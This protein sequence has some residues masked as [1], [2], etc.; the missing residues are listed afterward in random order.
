MHERLDL[1]LGL[2]VAPELV[3]LLGE[4]SGPL[5]CIEVE[6]QTLWWP[7]GDP[8]EPWRLDR[9][10]ADRL[11]ASG[12][13]VLA[14]GVSAPVGSSTPPD[15]PAVRAFAATVASVGAVHASEHLSFNAVGSGAARMD[16]GMF[17]PPCPTD[18][19][20]DRAVAA[21]RAHQ[22]RLDVPF[23]VETGVNY[24][25]PRRGELPDSEVVSRVAERA[26][27]GVLLDLHNLWCNERNGRERVDEAL[28][29]LPLERVVEVHVAG[30]VDLRGW[31]LDGHCDLVP[32]ELLAITADVL[33]ML[34]NARAVVFEI[35][36]L[37][38]GLLGI[39]RV[40]EHLGELARVVDAAR[41]TPLRRPPATFDVLDG[42]L[43][44][45]PEAWEAALA[46]AATGWLVDPGVTPLRDPATRLLRTLVDAGRAGRVV[47]GAPRTFGLLRD[48]LDAAGLDDLMRRFTVARRP[49]L[50][51]AD[52]ARRF[53]DWIVDE[54]R[55]PEVRAAAESDR[56]AIDLACAA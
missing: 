29:R 20:V 31:Y 3:D 21:V 34:P 32:P 52:E 17:L 26:D 33:P 54:L 7:T 10:A 27:C 37:H 56:A 4:L 47:R 41:R 49:A 11:V 22:A 12:L 53:L 13:P 28:A 50:F 48:D 2:V 1:G 9:A 5:G 44:T 16:T 25:R 43:D 55:T 39:E 19:G 6:P 40:R 35:L 8:D 30:G 14:H 18:A 15:E 38:V 42:D 23:A 24:L 45:T 51:G 36:P 46:A